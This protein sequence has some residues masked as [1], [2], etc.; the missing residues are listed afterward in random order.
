VLNS[1]EVERTAGA[2]GGNILLQ[3]PGP[4]NA[5]WAQW[6]GGQGADCALVPVRKVTWGRVKG[7]YR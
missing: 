6:N 7:I 2:P 5:N 1:I 3:S 4:G